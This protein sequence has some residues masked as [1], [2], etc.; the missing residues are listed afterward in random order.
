MYD[1]HV[2]FAVA[3]VFF[4]IFSY[5]PYL[6]DIFRGTTK[7]HPFTWLIWGLINV[8]A[9]F[10]Q[11]TEGGGAGAWVTAIV[12]V[13]CLSVA[14]LAFVRGELHIAV[15]DWICFSGALMGVVLWQITDNPFL[16]ILLVT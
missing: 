15:I 9:F 4:Q 14:A 7:P 8:I 12:A 1:Y 13:G 2:L 6:R 16:A 10:A 3:S 5:V 11:F